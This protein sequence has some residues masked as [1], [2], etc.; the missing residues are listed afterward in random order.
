MELYSGLV[1]KR[2]ASL[3]Y[4]ISCQQMSLKYVLYLRGGTSK[5]KPAEALHSF[6]LRLFLLLCFHIHLIKIPQGK[7]K[8]QEA[9]PTAG[10]ETSESSNPTSPI[11]YHL[12]NPIIFSVKSICLIPL[13][14]K[15]N[16]AS[17]SPCK[18]NVQPFP[19]SILTSD[20]SHSSIFSF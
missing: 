11:V 17:I 20:S 8:K 15:T 19:G 3:F 4:S 16:A 10:K 1:T 12:S 13:K 2:N 7:S 9:A 6:S 18:A 14:N 5:T